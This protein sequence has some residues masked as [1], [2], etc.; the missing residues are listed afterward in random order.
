MND[1]EKYLQRVSI[2]GKLD[3]SYRLSLENLHF[4]NIKFADILVFLPDN[5]NEAIDEHGGRDYMEIIYD[6]RNNQLLP[7]INVRFVDGETNQ[8]QI[9]TNSVYSEIYH[10]YHEWQSFD[11]C[12]MVC[13]LDGTME[14]SFHGG[15]EDVYGDLSEENKKVL[16]EEITP[17]SLYFF[18]KDVLNNIDS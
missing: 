11:G 14:A 4:Q 9:Y 10:T 1:L 3:E 15:L 8:H 17:K 16:E 12:F 6:I 18:L 13:S 7:S 2:E 5:S